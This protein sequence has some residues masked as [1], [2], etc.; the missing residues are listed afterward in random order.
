MSWN[1]SLSLVWNP[2]VDT[3]E[4]SE[5]MD[6]DRVSGEIDAFALP[7]PVSGDMVTSRVIRT[8]PVRV[9]AWL[10]KNGKYGD[11]NIREPAQC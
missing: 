11:G 3:T 7:L 10:R 1:T 9:L 6:V 8:T 2:Q 4:L 5:C